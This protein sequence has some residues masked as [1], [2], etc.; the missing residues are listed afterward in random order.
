M[1]IEQLRWLCSVR[2]PRRSSSF[3]V[4]HIHI[5]III[6]QLGFNQDGELSCS[7]ANHSFHHHPKFP[8]LFV[9]DRQT[10]IHI[11]TSCL[12]S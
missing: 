8:G 1:R 9:G 11:S 5:N 7:I 2:I 3:L 4:I 6:H 12:S 10:D